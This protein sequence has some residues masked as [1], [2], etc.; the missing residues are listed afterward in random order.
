M[1][2][3]IHDWWIGTTSGNYV[4]MGVISEGQYGIPRG[5][6][7]SFPV[8]CANGNNLKLLVITPYSIFCC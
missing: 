5:I 4:S 1:C 8:E 6:N 3:H 2:D 7:F